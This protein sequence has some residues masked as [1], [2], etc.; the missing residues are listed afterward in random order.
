M[1]RRATTW[2]VHAWIAILAL[3]FSSLAPAAHHALNP[4]PAE[5]Q[6]AEICTSS[7][8]QVVAVDAEHPA[9]PGHIHD[10]I[11]H[12]GYCVVHGGWQALPSGSHSGHAVAV[13]EYFAPSPSY[14]APLQPFPW[15]VAPS[16]APP[17]PA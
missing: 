14:A 7:G 6:T 10:S 12:C 13:K 3:L 2:A 16:R 5:P 4:A 15:T 1:H 9:Q 17:H 8:V 11:K